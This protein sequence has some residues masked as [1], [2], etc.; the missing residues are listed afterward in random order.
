M[1]LRLTGPDSQTQEVLVTASGLQI[2]RSPENEV[3][4]DEPTVSRHHCAL[5]PDEEGVIFLSDVGSRYG[6]LLNGDRLSGEEAIL[7]PG[8]VFQIGCWKGEIFDE[9]LADFSQA[10][11]VDFEVTSAEV[12]MATRKTRLLKAQQT[13]RRPTALYFLLLAALGTVGALL[14]TYVLFDAF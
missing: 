11:T 6:T 5:H 7:R 2:G 12:P 14:L 3:V 13:R 4:I 1:K 8:D 9:T 10:P